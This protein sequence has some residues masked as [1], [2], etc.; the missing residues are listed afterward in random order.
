MPARKPKTSKGTSGSAKSSTRSREPNVALALAAVARA[1][2]SLKAPWYLF[3][4]QAVALYGVPRT[5]ADVDVTVVWNAD[6]AK[7]VAALREADIDPLIDDAEFL[8]RARVIPAE[9]RA[10]GWRLDVVLGGTG[11]EEHIAAEAVTMSVGKLSFPVLRLEHLVVLKLLAAR[12]QDLADVSRLLEVRGDA[13]ALDEVR[14]LLAALE[15][16][17]GES[18]L[19]GRLEELLRAARP[20]P[21]RRR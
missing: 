1:A 11:L 10:S 12:P 5:T 20:A 15:A 9:H 18:D 6:A 2:R 21:P 17:L 13:I 7:V 8:E 3:G 4:A 16:G 14:E 19:L